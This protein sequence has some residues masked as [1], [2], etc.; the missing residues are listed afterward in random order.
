MSDLDL[1]ALAELERKATEGPWSPF[2]CN[3]DDTD[4]VVEAF[5]KAARG[6]HV[7]ALVRLLPE[8]EYEQERVANAQLI[9]M[10][11]NH[12]RA[13]IAEARRARE[14]VHYA[15]HEEGCPQSCM[16]DAEGDCSCGLD[17]LLRRED[18]RG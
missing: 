15:M 5:G 7:I 11:R 10:L 6:D 12:A 9:S 3:A 1:D 17:A 2:F 18:E 4:V 13:L 14:L 16:T 8:S